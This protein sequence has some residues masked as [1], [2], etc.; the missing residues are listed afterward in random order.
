MRFFLKKIGQPRIRQRLFVERLSEPMHLNLISLLVALVGS[1]R[2]KIDYDLILRQQH[3]YGLLEAA[4][5][6][7][8][9]RIKRIKVVEFGVASGAGL[10]NMSKIA[11]KITE[12]TGVE[13]DIVGFDTGKGMPP[14]RDYRDHPDTYW[15]GNYP[16]DEEA[17]RRVLPGSTTLILGDLTDTVP[18]FL[19]SLVPDAPV[20]FI[21]LDVDYYWSTVEA[22]RVF[23]GSA[24]CYLPITH[25]YV[26]DIDLPA[27]NSWAGAQLAIREFN[28]QYVQRKIER[29]HLLPYWRIFKNASWLAHMYKLHVMDHPI[30]T[31]LTKR[32]HKLTLQNPYL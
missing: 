25:V 27:H 9:G 10:V 14:P 3:A 5:Q 15:E 23:S 29:D 8:I 6:A 30:R 19:E 13:I 4:R 16:L 22:L 28:D 7:R 11:P 1:Y 21:S 20:G 32:E 24:D 2:R 12:I 26:D 18:S 31:Q 17:L